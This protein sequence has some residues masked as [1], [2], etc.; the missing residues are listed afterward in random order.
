[1]GEAIMG[2]SP[3]VR[4]VAGLLVITA[5]GIP[6]VMAAPA[7][8]ATTLLSVA[9]DGASTNGDSFHPALSADGS[10]VAFASVATN[11]TGSGSAG[12]VNVFVRDRTGRTVQASDAPDGLAGDGDSGSPVLSG[13][14]GV[15]AFDSF[16]T[17][18]V[19]GDTNGASDV[20]VR[21]RTTGR[22][23]RVSVNSAG[24]E[25]NA[26]SFSPSISADGG[27]VAFASDASG[28][29][30]GDHN[31]SGDVFVHDRRTG[32]TSRVSVASDGAQGN[33]DSFSPAISANGRFVAFVSGATNLVR[34][35]TNGATD[36]FVHDRKTRRT[37]RVSVAFDG[38]Q[39]NGDAYSPSISG[40]GRI[41]AFVTAA[42]NAAPADDNG[43]SDVFVHDRQ[44]GS[45][46]LVSADD[47]GRLSDRGSFAPSLSADGRGVAF[48]TDAALVADDRNNT[49]DVFVF[50]L[51]AGVLRRVSVA[52]DGREGSRP[53]TGPSISG[54]AGAVA[55]ESLA[56]NL[57]AAD[58]NLAQDVFWRR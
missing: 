9:S 41:V 6:G 30:T 1:M 32:Q 15:V 20:F 33:G 25:A 51:T 34:G 14:G 28:L 12:V 13:D 56:D 40:D 26:D 23:S 38:R 21:E 49:E 4:L 47:Q 52:S 54:D 39:L 24:V 29:V 45:T 35:D 50:D 10:T 7:A 43:A 2:R 27:V 58:S 55:F 37:T 57:V 8:V 19:S 18:L 44:T 31:R 17:N 16:A 3:H 22:T 53:S 11:L 5:L 42:G 46:L 36:V 48:V